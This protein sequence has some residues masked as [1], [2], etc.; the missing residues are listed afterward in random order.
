M[1]SMPKV[2]IS[3]GCSGIES[4]LGHLNNEGYT[5]THLR[6]AYH[7]LKNYRKRLVDKTLLGN[8]KELVH[9]KNDG[10]FKE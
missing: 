7:V 10:A 2:V 1:G 3:D 5:I 4:A 9:A 6:D 8:L